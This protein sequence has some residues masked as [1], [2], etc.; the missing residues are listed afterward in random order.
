M[1]PNERLKYIE[2][3]LV[4]AFNPTELK[5]MDDSAQHIGHAGAINGAGHYSIEIAATSFKNIS[6]LT[7]HRK[8]YQLFTNLIPDEIHALQIKIIES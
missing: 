4:D 8:I 6:K 3:K 2:L 7:A 5:V 1:T